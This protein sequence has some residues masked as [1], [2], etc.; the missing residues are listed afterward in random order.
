MHVTYRFLPLAGVLLLAAAPLAGAQSLPDPIAPAVVG[1][2]LDQIR[3]VRP[4]HPKPHPRPQAAGNEK[5]VYS[6]PAAAVAVAPVQ[7]QPA[8]P[9][10]AAQALEELRQGAPVATRQFGPGAYFDSRDLALV[11][12]YYATHPMPGVTRWKIGA[13]VPADSEITGVPDDVRA[14]LPP[15][16]A[17]HQ[18]VQLD[19]EVVLV[20]V[21]SRVVLDGISRG[22]R[23]APP[24]PG[25]FQQLG[26]QVARYFTRG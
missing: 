7:E 11:R 8:P 17:G 21:Q 3:P 18:Y 20:A 13:P 19:G 12:S 26:Q 23:P 4:V 25:M 22:P 10:V 16:P 1:R 5:V 24:P 6:R 15:P 14:A 2:P 9:R